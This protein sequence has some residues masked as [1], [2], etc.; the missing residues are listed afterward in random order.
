[1]KQALA[2]AA[3]A[4]LLTCTACTSTTPKPGAGALIEGWVAGG[5]DCYSAC[6]PP[7][8]PTYALGVSG[9]TVSASSEDGSGSSAK[10][11]ADG[12]YDLS[13]APGAYTV[14]AR[15]TGQVSTET[16]GWHVSVAQGQTTSVLLDCG[17]VDFATPT[18]TP[19]APQ[20]RVAGWVQE[21]GSPI[22]NSHIVAQAPVTIKKGSTPIHA[23]QAAAD[24]GYQQDL[25]PGGYWI[26]AVCPATASKPQRWTPI[27]RFIVTS[28]QTTSIVLDCYYTTPPDG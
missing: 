25:P 24:G 10:S 8:V 6:P 28:G 13:V 27:F 5:P 15:C 16:D 7:G 19:G 22:E 11:D 20:G 4:L 3:A 23:L 2:F 18:P 9:A 21:E 17:S 14:T 12:K 26:S 1:M